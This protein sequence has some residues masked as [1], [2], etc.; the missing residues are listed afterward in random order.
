QQLQQ[1]QQQQ[2][3]QQ[4]AL[5]ARQRQQQQQPTTLT[6]RA[7]ETQ[8]V[9]PPRR[10]AHPP[11]P[12][13]MQVRSASGSMPGTLPSPGI[14]Q[15]PHEAASSSA[16]PNDGSMR[17]AYD[18]SAATTL[19]TLGRWA[20]IRSELPLSTTA[21]L[22]ERMK[23]R[24]VPGPTLLARRPPLT[25]DQACY[26]AALFHLPMSVFAE[27]FQIIDRSRLHPEFLRLPHDGAGMLDGLQI[28]DRVM[29]V[30]FCILY[31]LST[32][33][34]GNGIT[35]STGGHPMAIEGVQ[36]ARPQHQ[37]QQP[38]HQ[39]QRPRVSSAAS[40][41]MHSPAGAPAQQGMHGLAGVFNQSG[42]GLSSV[43]SPTHP[44][45]Q[46]FKQWPG[47]GT[48]SS[49]SANSPVTHSAP[50]L[51]A[52][53][54]HQSYQ[55]PVMD[56]STHAQHMS[57]AAAMQSPLQMQ[58]PQHQQQ[59]VQQ[60]PQMPSVHPEHNLAASAPLASAPFTGAAPGPSAFFQNP[61]GTAPSSSV[62][63]NPGIPSGAHPMASTTLGQGVPPV[64]RTGG[65]RES[66]SSVEV[67]S[68]RGLPQ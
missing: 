9:A 46:T 7:P 35:K 6:G 49:S 23:N 37:Q 67:S 51:D 1:Q 66:S 64:H 26:Y 3:Q 39:Q 22:E 62:F 56:P 10:R 17:I 34:V 44:P 63:P 12:P 50:N 52:A 68:F 53:S 55:T 8:L 4:A 11:R 48:P 2:Q 24:E 16:R 18:S 60:M 45:S 59:V 47:H 30:M 61:N 14:P 36:P 54:P 41:A 58:F 31:T 25:N 21:E 42:V 38:Q 13:P 15:S 29:S 43:Q 33:E 20:K 19:N 5:L 57:Q 28:K 32:I 27:S 65:S 40:A